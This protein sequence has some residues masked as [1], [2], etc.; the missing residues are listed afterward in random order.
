MKSNILKAVLLLPDQAGS[1]SGEDERL[2]NLLS[3]G[4]NLPICKV[5]GRDCFQGS[6]GQQ[7]D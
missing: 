3:L 6:Q 2:G 4:L 1:Q 5:R 7:S